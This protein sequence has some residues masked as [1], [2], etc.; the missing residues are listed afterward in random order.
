MLSA[1]ELMF[2]NC[3]IGEYSWESTGLQ[4]DQTSQLQ[5]K[6][7]L[8]IYWKDWCWNSSTLATDVK[9]I[10]KDPDAG[11]EWGHEVKRVIE[12]EMFGQHHQLNGHEFEQ[13]PGVGDGQAS[14]ACCSPWGHRVGHDW[15][16]E[17]NW[18]PTWLHISECLSLGNWPHHHGYPGY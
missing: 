14:L 18:R 16:T 2:L 7:T 1:E 8:N 17:W 6:S 5:S 10:R 3:G 9:S 11:K 12:N 4:G 13:A 15:V